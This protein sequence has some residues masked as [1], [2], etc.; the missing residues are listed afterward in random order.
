MKQKRLNL[1]LAVAVAL[2]AAAVYFSQKKP[3]PKGPPLTA[4]KADQIDKITLHHA[5]QPDIVLQKNAGQWALTAPVQVA[6]DPYQVNSLLDIASEETKTWLKPQE[7]KLADL[8][9]DPPGMSLTLNDVKIDFGGVEPLDFKRY[10]EVGGKI[11]LID[12]PPGTVLDADYSDLVS[13]SLLPP[14]ARL[15]KLAL[16][17][18]TL[19]RSADGK[20]WSVDPPDPKA[21]SDAAQKLVDAWS[22]AQ[23]LWNAMTPADAKPAAHPE[24]ASLTL[25]DGHT[26]TFEIVSH[27]PQLV[28]ERPDLKLRYSLSKEEDDKLF[29]LAQAKPQTSQNSAASD[30]AAKPAP[31][32]PPAKQ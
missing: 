9:L 20:S 28:L 22:S 24:T 31:P 4:L 10:V 16:P 25:A 30:S 32:S 17:G 27:E 1:I 21:E 2:L 11:A 15:V 18:L 12:D 7:V 8:G 13:K 14:E 29:K 23:A 19:T 5:G 3:P 6:A 26:L